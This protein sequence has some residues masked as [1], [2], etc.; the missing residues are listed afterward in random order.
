MKLIKPPEAEIEY[1]SQNPLI[2]LKR[3]R[4]KLGDLYPSEEMISYEKFLNENYKKT[5]HLWH[6]GRIS[7]Y[8]VEIVLDK[9][10]FITYNE[11]ME[12][13]F[14]L[15]QTREISPKEDFVVERYKLLGSFLLESIKIEELYYCKFQVDLIQLM[16]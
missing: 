15:A 14:N 10:E 8:P 1:I 3:I 7:I 5:G 4:H 9:D 16:D 13:F 6:M 2:P 11:K 12:R